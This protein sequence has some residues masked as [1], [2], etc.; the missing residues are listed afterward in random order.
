[1]TGDVTDEPKTV[2]ERIAYCRREIRGQQEL[3]NWVPTQ[4]VNALAYR[5]GQAAYNAQQFEQAIQA[6]FPGTAVDSLEAMVYD[7]I[8]IAAVCM[9]G[10]E[11]LEEL[12]STAT[13]EGVKAA[14]AETMD[15]IRKRGGEGG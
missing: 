2:E 7:L 1:M 5:V 9:D 13:D 8:C 15:K 6:V 3:P 12:E 4:W 10:V 11:K 14:V